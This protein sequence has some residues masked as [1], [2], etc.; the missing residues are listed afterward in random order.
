MSNPPFQFLN[1]YTAQNYL[2]KSKNKSSGDGFL[3]RCPDSGGC[4]LITAQ[5]ITR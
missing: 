4:K 2:C 1:H 5:K 3:Y